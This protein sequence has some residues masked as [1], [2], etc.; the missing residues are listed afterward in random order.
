MADYWVSFRIRDEVR[1]KGDYDARY[2][3]MNAA[4]EKHGTGF[5]TGDTSMI[6]VRTNSLIDAL[7]NDIKAAVDPAVDKVVMREIGKDSTRY[8]GDP[9]DGFLAFFP[10]AK[11]L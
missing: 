4:L 7:G 11:K 5:W 2:T 1:P 3:A 6:C 8:I 10:K 9:G